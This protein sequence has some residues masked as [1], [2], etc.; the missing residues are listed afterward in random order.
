MEEKELITLSKEGSHEAFEELIKLYE[1]QIYNIAYRI[2][3]DP[4]DAMDISQDSLI[5]I[6]NNIK[7]FEERSKFSTWIFRIVTN[8]AIDYVKKHRKV[9]LLSIEEG[10]AADKNSGTTVDE[11]L[12]KSE[13]VKKVHA[14]LEKIDVNH[15]AVVILKDIYGFSYSEIS[16]ILVINEGTVKSRLNRARKALKKQLSKEEH[17]E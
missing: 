14:A 4:Q 8:S 10:I 13:N 1:K 16:K 3:M 15:R 5:K 11:E 7:Y 17:Y 12:E 6:Y 9:K 2:A